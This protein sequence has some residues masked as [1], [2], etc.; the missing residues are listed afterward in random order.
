VGHAQLGVVLG[1]D[2]ARQTAA[3]HQ[4]VD[5][6]GVRVALDEHM[7]A[8]FG[9]GQAQRMVA[10]GGAVGEKPRLPGAVGRGRQL[11]GALVRGGRGPG[12][13]ALDVLADVERERALADGRA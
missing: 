6:A 1:R 2:E 5:D 13:D 3:Q 10:L 11:L 12:V 9:H 4:P 7:A 8:G